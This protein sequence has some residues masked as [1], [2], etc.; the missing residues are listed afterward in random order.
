MFISLLDSLNLCLEENGKT[1]D[2]VRWVGCKDFYI[3]LWN[4]IALADKFPFDGYSQGKI[5][6]DIL[7]VG[8]DWWVDLFCPHF[9]SDKWTFKSMPKYPARKQVIKTLDVF[10]LSYDE[11]QEMLHE[12]HKDGKD[13]NVPAMWQLLFKK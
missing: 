1:L 3:P 4:F 5:P 13:C 6:E 8:D 2:D 12:G 11:T 7:V 9:G 10:D